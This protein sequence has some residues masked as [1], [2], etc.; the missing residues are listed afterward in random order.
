MCSRLLGATTPNEMLPS[1]LSKQLAAVPRHGC[2]QQPI[3]LGATTPSEGLRFGRSGA[4]D[5]PAGSRSRPRS[6]TRAG[7]AR[8]ASRSCR[9]CAIRR[10][11]RSTTCF[12]GGAPRRRRKSYLDSLINSQS[13]LR[14]IN[15]DLLVQLGSIKDNS[16]ASQI[17]AAIVLIQMKVTPVGRDPTSP[18]GGD[19]HNDSA[20]RHRGQ[21]DRDRR[22]VD[23][24]R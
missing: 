9:T 14:G 19:N 17:S 7:P 15:Q 5:H 18:F 22:G 1:L 13:E 10:C 12:R 2:Q 16:V 8:R 24:R 21:A 23:S 3:T 4:A 20:A 6:R 11:R